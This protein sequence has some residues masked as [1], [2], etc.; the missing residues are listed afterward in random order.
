MMRQKTLKIHIDEA[1]GFPCDITKP[2]SL[3]ERVMLVEKYDESTGK[4]WYTLCRSEGISGNVDPSIKKYHGW[5]GTTSGIATFAH[6]LREVIRADE[7]V[8]A[9]DDFGYYQKVTVG[10]DLKPSED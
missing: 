2:L 3:G 5:R 7:P 6:G 1:C 9:T 8:E 10:K 4:S